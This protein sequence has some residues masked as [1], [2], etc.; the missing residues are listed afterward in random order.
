[1]QSY[2]DH[3]RYKMATAR[4]AGA[5][6][7]Y[8]ALL[9]ASG[10]ES[11]LFRDDISHPFRVNPYFAEWV[12]VIDQPD[13]YLWIDLG[14]ESITLLAPGG[15]DVW[16]TAPPPLPEWV[17][18]LVEVREY[19]TPAELDALVASSGKVGFIG[20]AESAPEGVSTENINPAIVLSHIDFARAVKSEY[21]LECLRAANA[22]ASLGHRAV[23]DGFERGLSEYELLLEYLS[24]TKCRDQ[25]LPYPSII[26]LNENAAV[27]HHMALQV[28][29]PAENR[30][31]LID[32]GASHLGYAADI[33]RTYAMAKGD[34]LFAELV[35]AVDALQRRLVTQLG[36]V[37]SYAALHEAAYRS[38]AG[39]MRDM[40]LLKVA[41]D[42]ALETGL[43]NHFMPHGVGHLIGA[44]VHDK[45]GY[46]VNS[47][48]EEKLPPRQ[49]P[50]LRC[51][52]DIEP[53]MVFTVEP[54]I[55]FIPSLLEQIDDAERKV[56]LGLV[57]R[58]LPYGG[59]RI[60]DNVVVH[61]DGVEN[62]T[63]ALL[64]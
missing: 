16:H 10:G 31:L 33:S 20:R 15:V 29:A 28:H 46:L 14:D 40:G 47:W 4:R 19:A 11:M 48:G 13:R 43:V 60:E 17:L 45:G 51:T 34:S 55:Y 62:I 26:A 41:V 35:S 52:R 27:L 63:R 53:G 12:P 7:G 1:M 6:A 57:S 21:E 56:D 18:G 38:I 24:A 23:R 25:Q 3:L 22:L 50:A 2:A 58:L 9:I 61:A 44:H 39:V 5:A 8:E 64:P 30:S 32:A 54:G 42:E 59:V 36:S 37:S 49:F